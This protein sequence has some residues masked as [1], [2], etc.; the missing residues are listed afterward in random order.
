[1]KTL[2]TRFFE[3]KSTPFSTKQVR[4]GYLT[5]CRLLSPTI[6]LKLAWEVVTTIVVYSPGISTYWSDIISSIRNK[7]NKLSPCDQ[8]NVV[9]ALVKLNKKGRIEKILTENSDIS[10]VSVE[11]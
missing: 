3:L 6:Y 5:I 8:D 1:M 7:W 2:D 11:L 10:G 4:D 9:A